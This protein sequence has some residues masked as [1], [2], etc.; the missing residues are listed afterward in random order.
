[1]LVSGILLAIGWIALVFASIICIF[2]VLVIIRYA[3]QS[4]FR[5]KMSSSCLYTGRVKHSRLKGGAI[6]H[7]NYPLF[8]AYIDLDQ[9]S[10]I[11]WNLWP[12]FKID[13]GWTTFCSLDYDQHLKGWEENSKISLLERV[14]TFVQSH[15]ISNIPMNSKVQLLTHLTYFGYCFNPVSFYFLFND[16][17]STNQSKVSVKNVHTIIAEV[18][19]TPW[20]EQHSYV[21]N[22][23]TKDSTIDWD[24][25]LISEAITASWDKQFHVSPF[26]QMDYR[27]TF[28]FSP[29]GDDVIHVSARMIK[30]STKEVWFTASFEL[31]R[32]PF[33]PLNLLYVLVFYP[34]H[35]R[36]IQV[37]IHIEAV[38]IFLKGVPTFEHPKGTDVDFGWGITGKRLGYVL[39]VVTK[40]FRDVHDWIQ[41]MI[42]AVIRNHKKDS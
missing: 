27:Y 38:K 29:P 31:K 2:L 34:L 39:Y 33:S 7:L 22:H 3:I 1:M 6:H 20:N 30:L 18:S 32:I 41:D 11:G 26:M 9:I 21:L 16:D 19:N 23:D 12:I 8:F 36:I 28:S 13:G 42:A 40:P 5:S 35:T 37:W 14:R 17:D 15:T 4:E 24:C 25:N 10:N